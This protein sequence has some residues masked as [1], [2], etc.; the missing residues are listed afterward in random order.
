MGTVQA[1]LAAAV[2]LVLRPVM[3]DQPW[4]A[5]RVAG[6]GAGLVIDDPSGA[7]SAVRTVLTEPRYRAAAQAAAAEIRSMPAPQAALAALL[8]R[9][10]A[11]HQKRRDLT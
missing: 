3:A 9:S 8:V 11:P 6:A 5:R 7:G 4:N 1:A 10:T 2:P